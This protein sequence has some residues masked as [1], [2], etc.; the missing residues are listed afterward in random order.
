MSST[1]YITI[2]YV[3]YMVQE[4]INDNIVYGGYL[5]LYIL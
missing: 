5:Y 1:T 4:N 2:P 3:T